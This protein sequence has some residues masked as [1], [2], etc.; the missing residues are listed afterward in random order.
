MFEKVVVID[1]KDH[2]LGRLASIVGKELMNGQQ[3]VCVRTEEISMSGSLFRNQLIFSKYLT[4]RGSTNPGLGPYHYRSP[5]RILWRT[6]RGMMNHFKKRGQAALGR[7]KV[8]EGVPHPYDKQK[9]VV[10]PLAIRQLRLRPGRKWT[11]LGDLSAAVGWTHN[12]I[13]KRL[14]N[15]RKVRAAAWYT[16]K[17]QLT[18]LRQRAAATVDAKLHPEEEKRKAEVKA[19]YA[20]AKK[21]ADAKQQA[22]DAAAAKHGRTKA[23]AAP[24]TGAKGEKKGEKKAEGGKGEH[25]KAGAAKGADAA[26]GAKKAKS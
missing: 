2:M 15:K 23:A 3:V 6:L 22:R 8:F 21:I 9:K 10:I 16:T 1:C 14:E 19:L 12:A 25:K 24:T 7:L 13:I 5:S 26:K 11:R 18:I 17:K 20:D 4:H